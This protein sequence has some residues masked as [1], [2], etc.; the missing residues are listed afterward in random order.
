VLHETDASLVLVAQY[1]DVPGI[2]GSKFSLHRAAGSAFYVPDHQGNTRVLT[3]AT[4]AV[5]DT[6]LTDAWGVEVAAS[7]ATVNPYRA[8][9]AWG[10]ERDN[11]SRLYVRARELRVDLG[12]WVSRDPIGFGGGDANLSRYVGN[13]PLAN[14]DAEGLWGPNVHYG[15]TRKWLQL[16]Y[17]LCPRAAHIIA[18]WTWQADINDRWND[19][20]GH[21]YDPPWGGWRDR[22]DRRKEYADQQIRMATRY[23]SFD[24]C[25]QAFAH[26][27]T[28]LHYYEDFSAHGGPG[29][30]NWTHDLGSWADNTLYDCH[31]KLDRSQPRLQAA[32]RQFRDIWQNELA[33]PLRACIERECRLR[34]NVR[35]SKEWWNEHQRW[36]WNPSKPI[37]IR[38]APPRDRWSTPEP[39]YNGGPV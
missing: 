23:S 12:R 22:F 15:F 26:A 17:N 5:T 31:G 36:W 21:L 29:E 33:V 8:F 24:S 32:W 16:T 10:Y 28:A 19:Q 18:W 3:N 25:A 34:P 9:G 38:P 1:A 2:W 37:P 14:V 30:V 20:P 13:N 11:A 6:L 4:G 35:P 39:P 7:G 27:G